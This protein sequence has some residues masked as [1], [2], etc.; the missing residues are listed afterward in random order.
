MEYLNSQENITSRIQIFFNDWTGSASQ[1]EVKQA[2]ETTLVDFPDVFAQNRFDIGFRTELKIKLTPQND[3]PFYRQSF[4][5]PII[6]IDFILV[7]LDL[8]KKFG[9]ITLLFSKYA[10]PIL[11]Q[12]KL[13]GKLRLMF[14]M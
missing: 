14:D 4:A 3:K 11:A 2:V 5:V 6:F 1:P 9:I 10:S 12:K 7:E 8:L 13:N